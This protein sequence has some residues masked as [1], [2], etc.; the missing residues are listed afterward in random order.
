MRFPHVGTGIRWSCETGNRHRARTRHG[1]REWSYRGDR[2]CD[3]EHG[4][5]LATPLRVS[6]RPD[7][8]S[9]C[10]NSRRV[11]ATCSQQLQR[12]SIDLHRSLDLGN[13][14]GHRCW[15]AV[16]L[17]RHVALRDDVEPIGRVPIH[18]DEAHSGRACSC[19]GTCVGERARRC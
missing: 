7:H 5:H 4:H 6:Q 16:C 13:A 18:N 3:D 15:R 17:R 11:G 9:I 12:I 1:N 2:E 10:C 8:G 19:T 14:E